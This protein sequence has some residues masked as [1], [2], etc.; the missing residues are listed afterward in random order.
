MEVFFM[1]SLIMLLC[2]GIGNLMNFFPEKGADQLYSM[3]GIS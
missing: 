1:F 2:Y 3:E